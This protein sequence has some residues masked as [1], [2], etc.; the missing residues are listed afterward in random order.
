MA[1]FRRKSSKRMLRRTGRIRMRSRDLIT[2]APC[3]RGSEMGACIYRRLQS[4]DREER[5]TDELGLLKRRGA[6]STESTTWT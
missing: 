5:S 4:R 6:P 3:G 1:S 2:S